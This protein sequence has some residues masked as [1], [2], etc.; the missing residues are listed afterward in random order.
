[1]KILKR[2]YYTL[3]N[4]LRNINLEYPKFII[5]NKLYQKISLSIQKLIEFDSNSHLPKLHRWC[6]TTSPIYKNKCDWEKKTN[7]ANI[8]NSF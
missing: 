7:Q 2:E 5:E 4:E 8:D 3:A 1:M 6:N